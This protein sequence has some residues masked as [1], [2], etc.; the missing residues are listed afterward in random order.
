MKDFDFPGALQRFKREKEVGRW[1]EEER[2]KDREWDRD[3]DR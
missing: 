3:G 1:R 2:G